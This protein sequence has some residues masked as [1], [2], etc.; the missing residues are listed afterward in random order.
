MTKTKKSKSMPLFN[1]I[2]VLQINLALGLRREFGIY[3][4]ENVIL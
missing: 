3:F 1:I 4:P 2:I